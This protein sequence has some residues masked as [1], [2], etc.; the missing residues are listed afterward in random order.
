MAKGRERE[1]D[2][3]LRPDPPPSSGRGR[4]PPLHSEIPNLKHK[5][6]GNIK[7]SIT[8][9]PNRGRDK[10]RSREVYPRLVGG[11]DIGEDKPDPIYFVAT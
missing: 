2:I 10:G 3:H 9:K 7:A 4:A 11:D 5:I 1:A 8:G 6:P